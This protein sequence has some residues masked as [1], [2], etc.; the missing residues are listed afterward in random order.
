[1]RGD[2]DTDTL[3]LELLGR[4]IRR[5]REAAGITRVILAD[6]IDVS[7]KALELWEQGRRSPGLIYLLRLAWALNWSLD[8][9]IYGTEDEWPALL[10]RRNI[11]PYLTAK[12]SRLASISGVP[13]A[14]AA[15]NS[16]P[17]I[18]GD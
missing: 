8:S 7:S 13:C 6:R 9:L 16:T 1:M 18:P 17:V 4:R 12:P 3:Y 2:N 14:V 11:P 5:R 10:P 15:T